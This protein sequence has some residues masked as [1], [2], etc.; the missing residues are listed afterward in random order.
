MGWNKTYKKLFS[1]HVISKICWLRICLPPQCLTLLSISEGEKYF[2][3]T[4]FIYMETN[5]ALH[6]LPHNYYTHTLIY[7]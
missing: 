5:Y 7:K 1:T 3:H 6:N 2:S 4:I